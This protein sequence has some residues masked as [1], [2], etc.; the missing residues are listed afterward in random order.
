MLSLA[1]HFRVFRVPP[2][3]LHALSVLWLNLKEERF[4]DP[5]ALLLSSVIIDLEPLFVLT[6]GLPYPAHGFWHSYF[7]G[8]VVSLVLT[9][10]FYVFER[11]FQKASVRMCQV[12]RLKGNFPYGFR[13]IFLNC[14]FGVSFHVFLDSFTHRNFPYVLFPVYV[15]NSYSNPFWKGMETAISVEL[16]VL[17]LS[18]FSCALWVKRFV[19]KQRLLKRS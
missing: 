5:F 8:I 3:P 12:F 9:P 7:A 14:L 15:F 16:I 19:G 6:L 4:F 13:L 2:T 10:F 18:L 17:A 1:L 11:K